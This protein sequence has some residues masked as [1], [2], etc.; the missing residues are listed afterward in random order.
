[1]SKG[2]DPKHV[3]MSQQSFRKLPPGLGNRALPLGHARVHS[4]TQTPAKAR[5]V[6]PPISTPKARNESDPWKIKI[7]EG[8]DNKTARVSRRGGTRRK[9]R[10]L[11]SPKCQTQVSVGPDALQA[12]WW[13][14]PGQH[15]PTSSARSLGVDWVG[16]SRPGWMLDSEHP[17]PK[18]HPPG[19]PLPAPAPCS[20]LSSPR[21]V[22][23]A[24]PLRF[25]SWLRVQ[26]PPRSR[27]QRA[28]RRGG[29]GHRVLD[30][31]VSRVPWEHSV[32]AK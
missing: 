16:V 24:G 30:L 26:G 7:D 1:M 23:W 19:S 31:P 12:G 4:C 3:T 5:A 10:C 14:R 21:W 6:P 32:P 9:A 11:R 17:H 18:P 25:P 29:T 28:R 20:Q 8:E 2:G 22:R 13:M 27:S 15:A